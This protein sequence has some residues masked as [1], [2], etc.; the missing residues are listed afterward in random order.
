MELDP[1]RILRV[2]SGIFRLVCCVELLL[3]IASLSRVL[4]CLSVVQ[5][6]HNHIDMFYLIVAFVVLLCVSDRTRSRICGISSR[7]GLVRQ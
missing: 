3:S 1:L 4:L 6:L 2:G 5:H 7:V